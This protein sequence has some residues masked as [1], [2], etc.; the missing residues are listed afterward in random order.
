[1]LDQAA[2]LELADFSLRLNAQAIPLGPGTAVLAPDEVAFVIE[3]VANETFP[4]VYCRNRADD[5]RRVRVGKSSQR[6]QCCKPRSHCNESNTHG[7]LQK[8]MRRELCAGEIGLQ[9]LRAHSRVI[10]DRRALRW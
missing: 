1:M 3:I 6:N 7:T 2:D 9:G 4:W 5:G 10:G 8:R